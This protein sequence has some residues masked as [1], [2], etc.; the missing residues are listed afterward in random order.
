MTRI[1][2]IQNKTQLQLDI[3]D[4]RPEWVRGPCVKQT[5]VAII[6]N[7]GEFW[8]GSNWCVNPQEECPRKNLP[9]G[10]GYEMCSDICGQKNHAEVD[11]CLNAGV[12]AIGGTLYL[13]GHTYCCDNCIKVMEDSGI[14]KVIIGRYPL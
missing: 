8:F 4:Q 7:R 14:S 6:K 5:T 3:E 13:L 11:A 2:K 12:N 9:T 1:N 10:V